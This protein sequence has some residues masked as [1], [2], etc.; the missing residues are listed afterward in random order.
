VPFA[1]VWERSERLVA[2]YEAEA[3]RLVPDGAEL[4]DA[5]VHVGTDIDGMVGSLDDLLANFERAN[6]KR[7]FGFCLDEPDREPAFR[8][9]NDRTLAAAEASGGVLIPFVRLDLSAEPIA[10]ATRCLDLGAR[11]IKLHPRAQ[12]FHL[13]D[14]RLEGIFALAAERRVPILIHGGRGLPPIAEELERLVSGNP[15]TQLIIAHGGIADLG[16]LSEAFAGHPGVFYDTSVWSPVDL[17]DVYRRFSPEQA[18]FASDF[19]YGQQPTALMI[20][21]RVGHAAGLTEEQLAGMLGGTAARIA[22]GEPPPPFSSPSEHRTI[23]QP[24]TFARIL[25]YLTMATVLL[26][27]SQEDKIGV[28]GLAMNACRERDGFADERERIIELLACARELWPHAF[29]PEDEAER[30]RLRRATFRL[31]HLAQIETVTADG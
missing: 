3:A 29:E 12:A 6:I 14:E 1:D 10:E 7:G 30:M 20:A 9:A 15:G 17:L 2:L 11:G 27:T 28:L 4:F 18:L 13:N 25:S 19:P 23:E 5:H 21:L 26:W 31:I 24:V 16:A 8:A 22:D